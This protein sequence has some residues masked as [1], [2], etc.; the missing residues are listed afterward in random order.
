VDNGKYDVG[1]S[2]NGKPLPDDSY[3]FT[4]V[5]G[6]LFIELTTAFNTV[7]WVKDVQ[8]PVLEIAT[9]TTE[10]LANDSY[11]YFEIPQQ[12]EANPLQEEVGVI[13]GSEVMGHFASII[14]SQPGFEGE[15]YGASNN[16]R[17]SIKNASL[18]KH[19]LQNM[20][21]ALKSMLMVSEPDLDI[22]TAIRYAQDEYTKFKNRYVSTAATL[23][24]NEFSP[25]EYYNNTI[26]IG[27]WVDEIL[28]V[29]NVSKE[30]SKAFAYSYMVANG[31][32]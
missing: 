29:V 10:A 24:K 11:G 8:H 23:I 25:V 30:F 5:N 14:S 31:R 27:Q 12:L 4:T 13:S 17:D 9:Y 15:V 26:L 21:P 2:I 32:T 16:Y 18:G 6:D 7:P 22:I 28:K 19:I 20:T 1:A 3:Y